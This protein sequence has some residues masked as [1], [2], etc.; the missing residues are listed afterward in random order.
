MRPQHTPFPFFSSSS[1]TTDQLLRYGWR[2]PFLTGSLF[3]FLGIFL[4]TQTKARGFTSM[5]VD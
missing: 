2:I 4:R 5:H 3:G 1:T